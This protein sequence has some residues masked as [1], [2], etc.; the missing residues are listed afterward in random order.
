MFSGEKNLTGARKLS[1]A[2]LQERSKKGLCFKC[3]E[4]WGPEHSCKMKY[5]QLLLVEGR[6]EGQE[7]GQMEN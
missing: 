1:Q 5:Y 7:V 4:K 2:K 6:E 3:G